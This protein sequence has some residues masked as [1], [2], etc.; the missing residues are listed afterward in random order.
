MK[1]ADKLQSVRIILLIPA[2]NKRVRFSWVEREAERF[3]TIKGFDLAVFDVPILQNDREKTVTLYAESPPNQ[4]G[5]KH[6]SELSRPL[7]GWQQSA[8]Q[9]GFEEECFSA[10]VSNA[11]LGKC[12]SPSLTM[13]DRLSIG[14]LGGN[15]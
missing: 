12:A 8:H 13:M 9:D 1:A 7:L 3:K 2:D 6:A 5:W 4:L 10:G 14:V 11:M 15:D